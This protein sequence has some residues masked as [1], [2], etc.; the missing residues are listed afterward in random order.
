MLKRLALFFSRKRGKRLIRAAEDGDLE[1]VRTLLEAGANPNATNDGNF[2]ALICAAARGHVRVVKTLLESG[3][4]LHART[5]RGRTAVD[6]AIQEGQEEVTRLLR[7]AE[8]GA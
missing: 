6:I 8:G 4:N 3:A 1:L 7:A 2:T 5:K